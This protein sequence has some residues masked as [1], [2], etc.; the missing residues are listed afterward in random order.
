MKIFIIILFILIIL[1]IIRKKEDFD[2]VSYDT[3]PYAT[4]IPYNITP[5]M[6]EDIKYTK[7]NGIYLFIK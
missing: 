5:Q 2:G 1:Y 7:Y 3:I 4:T 6:A